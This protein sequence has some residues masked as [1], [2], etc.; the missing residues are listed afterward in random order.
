MTVRVRFA[1][2]PTGFMHLGNARTAL[3]NWLYA[4]HMGG[5]FIL[6][7]ED[8]DRERHTEAAVQV[9]YDSLKWMGLNWDGP[10]LRQSERLAIYH[11][12]AQKLIDEGKAYRCNCTR[13]EL[14][15]KKEA[16][17]ETAN[18][19]CYDGTCREKNLGPD[20]GTHVVRFKMPKEGESTFEDMIQGT[21]TKN[22][23]DLDDFIMVRSDGMPTYQFAVVVDDLALQIT[24]VIR[25]ADHIDNTHCQIALY[26]AL[27]K[28]PPR[29]AHAPRIDGLSKRKGSPSVE[30][31]REALGLLPEGL[32]NYIARLGWS[33]G[34]DEI[35]SMQELIEKF[36]ICDVNRANGEFDE[37]K[38]KW[39]N[40]QQLR[41]VPI[42]EIAD[43][44]LE[45]YEK[46]G[47]KVEKGE[48]LYKLLEM[49]RKRAHSLNEIVSDSLF[50][51]NAP[52]TYDEASVS[53][54]F[55]ADTPALLEDLA[56]AIQNITDWSET[57]IEAAFNEI[58]AN[59]SL[60]M[61]KVA[62]PARTAI[63]GIAQSPGIYEVVWFVGK[64]ETVRRLHKAA[65]FIKNR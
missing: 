1:P 26:H 16:M 10:V 12:V 39:V 43:H 57:A 63:V 34:D 24:H 30:Y 36:D 62:Q 7:I 37:E 33:H 59:R 25:G 4:R 42:E 54:H 56:N 21:I 48:W 18:H 61:G 5:Q 40:E 14:E 64:D 31:Y 35:F 20:C 58:A 6:R 51:W 60:K 15:A 19:A 28:E 45:R 3:F 13:E 41:L 22:Y 49:M 29:F 44:T 38:L 55:N 23:K 47:I 46:A 9:I 2:S 50:I 32:N 65:E 11:E 8:T 53:K 27:G 17:K 52:Q